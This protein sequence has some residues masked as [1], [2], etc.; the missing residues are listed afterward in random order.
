MGRYKGDTPY[1][2][3]RRSFDGYTAKAGN[4]NW[5]KVNRCFST[6]MQRSNICIIVSSPCNPLLTIH[7]MNGWT[8]NYFKEEN[9]YDSEN[10][11]LEE[12]CL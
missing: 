10:I 5:K 1:L 7:Y 2:G 8:Q 4:A 12:A 11:H 6:L 3:T 9:G